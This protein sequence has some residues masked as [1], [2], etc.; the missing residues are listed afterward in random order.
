MHLSQA[1]F[2]FYK[3]MLLLLFLSFFLSLRCKAWCGSTCRF[4][5]RPWMSVA[6]EV[7][8]ALSADGQPRSLLVN[9]I[10]AQRVDVLSSA[11]GIFTEN[12]MDHTVKQK[13]REPTT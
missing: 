2:F 3:K 7:R 6:D 4:L 5:L 1:L 10:G 13:K 8:Q 9:F 11:D 12:Y